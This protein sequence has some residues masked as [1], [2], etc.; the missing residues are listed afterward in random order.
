MFLDVKVQQKIEKAHTLSEKTN[1]VV[2]KT[3]LFSNKA[4]WLLVIGQGSYQGA[5]LGCLLEKLL[6]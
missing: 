6:I 1:K 5:F 4:S 2:S 3:S